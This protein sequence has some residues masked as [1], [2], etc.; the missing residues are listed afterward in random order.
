MSWVFISTCCDRACTHLL[1]PS[2]ILSTLKMTYFSLLYITLVPPSLL[3]T[4]MSKLQFSPLYHACVSKYL[5]AQDICLFPLIQYILFLPTKHAYKI[6]S[7]THAH[8]TILFFLHIPITKY[9][10]YTYYLTSRL[11]PN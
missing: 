5:A 4:R 3:G 7:N 8:I 9:L 6:F 1:Y 11:A 10:L 2:P